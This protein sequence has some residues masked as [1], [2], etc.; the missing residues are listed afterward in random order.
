MLKQSFI[1]RT[2]LPERRVAKTERRA[3]PEDRRSFL[4]DRRVSSHFVLRERRKTTGRR[5]SLQ[6]RRYCAD[7]RNDA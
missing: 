2:M 4:P 5:T 6:G 3:N 7:R 1:Q